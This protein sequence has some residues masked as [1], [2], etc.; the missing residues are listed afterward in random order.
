MK[1]LLLLFALA[2]PAFAA[3]RK[4]LVLVNGSLSD[5]PN[6]DTLTVGAGAKT[7]GGVQLVTRTAVETLT[8]KT[9]TAPV[10]NGAV[11]TAGLT[12]PTFAMGGV[13]ITG[14]PNTPGCSSCAVSKSYADSLV[15]P[16]VVLLNPGSPQSGNISITGSLT[17]GS[18]ALPAAMGSIATFT[19]DVG[20]GTRGILIKD[21]AGDAFS[22]FAEASPTSGVQ[23]TSVAFYGA[24]GGANAPGGFAGFFGGKG[25]SNADGGNVGF[26]AGE[27][28][29]TGNGGNATMF[30]GFVDG[31]GHF[32]DALIGTYS[33]RNTVIDATT[34][35]SI[36]PS[37]LLTQFGGDV[38]IAGKLYVTGQIDPTAVLLSGADKRFGATDSGTIYLAPFAN[39][40]TAVQ[41]RKADNTTAV[42]T[43]NTSTSAVTFAGDV[44][45]AT[46]N[47]ASIP[48]TFGTVTSIAS[49]NGLTGG[50]ITTSGSFAVLASNTTITV[51]AGGISVNAANLT[52]I[53]ESGVT[54]LVS[55][56]A[57]KQATGNYLTALSSDVVAAGPGSAAAT[58]QPGVVSYAKIQNISA[59]SKFLGRKTAGAGSTE[60]LSASDAKT[61]LAIS[62]GDVSGLGTLATL[63]SVDL[64]GAQATGT[65]AA[66]RLDAFTG[67]VTSSGYATT[68]AN[69]AVTYSKI[70]NIS[71]TSKFLGRKTAG[72]GSTEELSASDAKTILAISSSDVSGLG[73]LATLN[74]VDLSGSQATG[75]LAAARL[76]A[77]TGDVTSAGSS[78]ALSIGS[79]A[80]TAAKLATGA[81]DVSTTV[82]TGTLAAGRFPALTGDV[83]TS[84][85]A[86][87][88]TIAA[89]SVTLAKM[90]NMA[91][92]SILGR[93]TAGT[94]APE[95]LSAAT[96]KSLLSLNLVE[97]TAISTFAGST[98]IVTLGTVATGTW[99]A[100]TVAVNKGGT[101]Q[102]TYTNGQL[103]IGNT[104]GN[105][106][107]K[108]T[109][110]AGTG[111]TI[112]NST[113]SITVAPNLAANLTWTGT[114]TFSNS[115]V[116]NGGL[117]RSS[118]GTANLFT[119]AN[120][121][122]VNLGSSSS[123][124]TIIDGATTALRSAGNNMLL[125]DA[126]NDYRF[127]DHT[128]G[129]QW[130]QL[131]SSPGI[132]GNAS[133]FNTSSSGFEIAAGSGTLVLNASGGIVD[134]GTGIGTATTTNVS[135][136]T[137][138]LSSA[139]ALNIGNGGGIVKILN[140]SGDRV[141]ETDNAGNLYIESHNSGTIL[142]IGSQADTR[143]IYL[144]TGA[145]M[146]A[147]YV[148]DTTTSNSVTC[149]IGTQGST[150]DLQIGGTGVPTKIGGKFFA[151][152]ASGTAT[153]S[154]G[155][156]TV[157]TSY[158]TAG[159]QIQLT[160]NGTSLVNAGIISVGTIVAG[161]SF[162]INSANILDANQVNWFIVN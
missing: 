133:R 100:T 117:S 28:T 134:V 153:L 123:S 46:I 45:A 31:S 88:T 12:M 2:T 4:A 103:L 152:N 84:A 30:G 101:G 36:A 158:V 7:V 154:G 9:L 34:T 67:D 149:H 110:T 99:S 47:G 29:G 114:E 156:V 39:S 104:T 1:K 55:D 125:L 157:S 16:G 106:L 93:N 97:N 94:G 80:V 151:A 14:L 58:I 32:G 81:V 35:L 25:G 135:G 120:S 98:N 75:T 105:T 130:L 11:T 49:G 38:S 86:L 108:A 150:I 148:C 119:D 121:T 44:A 136:F 145:N 52:G 8:N 54:N 142:G 91:T 73:A 27:G 42:M 161:T 53:P 96:T 71:A 87:A 43:V 5:I 144:G 24:Q 115:I 51:A 112:T 61:I 132:G 26:A 56:L 116:A 162:V 3:D 102:T 23:G 85:G 122:N 57:G 68:I 15:P 83:T 107:T 90:A 77:Y 19:T 63:N 78:Y 139:T 111:I 66:A 140:G 160:Y 21:T 76:G 109:L 48:G 33:T 10:L 92:A 118:G 138:N 64:S 89:S 60:E 124:N 147:T 146:Q 159:S 17:A 128:G 143:S 72:A 18:I 129:T 6:G 137:V 22:I 40:S 131:T 79:G 95:V 126:A 13:D 65:L 127:F 50:P 62:S 82:V 20:D 141:L 155:T 74:S 70:Q 113:G 69:A 37:G 59:T 41:I